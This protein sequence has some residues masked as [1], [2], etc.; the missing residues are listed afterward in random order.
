MLPKVG[1]RNEAP[2]LER[3]ALEGKVVLLF[4]IPWLGAYPEAISPGT[5]GLPGTPGPAGWGRKWAGTPAQMGYTAERG[6]SGQVQAGT[7]SLDLTHFFSPAHP[8]PTVIYGPG[9]L[10]EPAFVSCVYTVPFLILV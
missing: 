7:V 9:P 5:R 8:A 10:G 6:S 2:F 3:G 1:T 4:W